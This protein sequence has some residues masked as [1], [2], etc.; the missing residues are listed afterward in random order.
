MMS[1][2]DAE[3][4]SETICY[5]VIFFSNAQVRDLGFNEIEFIGIRKL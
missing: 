1:G 5:D 3:N 2:K 4:Q